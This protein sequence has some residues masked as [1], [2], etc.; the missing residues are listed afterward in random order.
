MA[1]AALASST[2]KINSIDA[3]MLQS[4][5]R[6]KGK[7]MTRHAEP[8]HAQARRT[9]SAT[10][11][12]QSSAAPCENMDRLLRQHLLKATDFSIDAQEEL[13]AIAHRLP[14]ASC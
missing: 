7:R 8:T 2:I 1:A 12:A 10:H 11:V 6:D 3:S 5:T 9:T 14:P 4:L 13:D